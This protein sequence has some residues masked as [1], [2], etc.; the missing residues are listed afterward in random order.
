[1]RVDL[2]GAL[3]EV[4]NRQRC[5]G[6]RDDR[7]QGVGVRVA[8]GHTGPQHLQGY[9]DEA[10]ADPKQPAEQAAQ[11]TDRREDAAA[12]Y[13]GVVRVGVSGWFMTTE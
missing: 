5:D 11:K 13:S 1:M 3:A 12:V 9:E 6:D 4:V 7:H 2:R 8:L 10:S